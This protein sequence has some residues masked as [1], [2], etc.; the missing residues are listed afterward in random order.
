MPVLK[1]L[2][3][4]ID[5]NAVFIRQGFRDPS[6]MRP[7]MKE[8]AEALLEEAKAG[9]LIRTAVS[10]EVYP[11]LEVDSERIILG[12]GGVLNGSLLSSRLA[13]ASELVVIVSTIG[14]QLETRVKDYTT[15]KETLTGM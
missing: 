7:G 5:M 6:K 2:E 13:S 8:M 4:T 14:P 3:F 11:V 15:A 10:Y 9:R 12:G 1:D